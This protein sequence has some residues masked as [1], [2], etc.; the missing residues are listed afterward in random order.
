MSIKRPE[1]PYLTF[2]EWKNIYND[3]F[4]LQKCLATY[5]IYYSQRF[6]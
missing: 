3:F 2:Y 4:T 5:A 1:L 6:N